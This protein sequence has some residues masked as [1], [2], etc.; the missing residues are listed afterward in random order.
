MEEHLR[1]AVCYWHTFHG[2]GNDPFGPG[3][4]NYAWNQGAD[5]D[6]A[7]RNRLDA[8]FEFFSKLNVPFYCFHDR[9]MAPEGASI[10]ESERKLQEMTAI[11]AIRQ[12]ETG[13]LVVG[14]P[15]CSPTRAT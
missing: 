5:A 9:D 1:F 11:A 7:A 3:T 2:T 13:A 4:R 14:A 12:S 10:A 15:T 8:A 6:V